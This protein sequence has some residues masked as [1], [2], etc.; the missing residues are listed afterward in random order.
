MSET[1]SI[2]VV[3]SSTSSKVVCGNV[4]SSIGSGVVS[5][6]VVVGLVVC[7]VVSVVVDTASCS[8]RGSETGAEVLGTATG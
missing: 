7:D 4:S 3:V 2:L 5:G 1:G 6:R 8:G